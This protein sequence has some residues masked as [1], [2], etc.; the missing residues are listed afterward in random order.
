[1]D[2]SLKD[3]ENII[4]RF[5][6][7]SLK[8]MSL[9]AWGL[10]ISMEKEGAVAGVP[11]IVS[12]SASQSKTEGREVKSPLVGTFYA[13]PAPGKEP[14]TKEGNRVKAGDTIGLIE[15]MKIMNEIT[16]PSDGI[17]AEVLVKDG[18]FVAFDQTIFVIKDE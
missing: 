1:M 8:S 3:V 16:A 11:Q 4:D 14:Y 13:A 17:I 9:E 15:A 5:E 7:G 10:K 12:G 18:E 6:K 2:I